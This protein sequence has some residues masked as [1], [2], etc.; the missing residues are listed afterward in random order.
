MEVLILGVFL[1]I[2]FLEK[3]GQKWGCVLYTGAHY[4]QVNTVNRTLQITSCRL[5]IQIHLTNLFS[6]I[7]LPHCV[8]GWMVEIMVTSSS[9][10]GCSRAV[11]TYPVTNCWPSIHYL[12]TIISIKHQALT[13]AIYR[14]FC[15]QTPSLY[16]IE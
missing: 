10:T 4:T 9:A 5:N 3:R 14:N 7:L 1:E 15:Y 6:F 2:L 16:N 8:S 11:S 12:L 13:K